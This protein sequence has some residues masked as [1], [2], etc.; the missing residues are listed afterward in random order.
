MKVANRQEFKPAADKC[1]GID[2]GFGSQ[3]SN[4]DSAYNA[5]KKEERF[6]VGFRNTN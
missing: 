1:N 4:N 3:Q 5:L 6:Y 2:N